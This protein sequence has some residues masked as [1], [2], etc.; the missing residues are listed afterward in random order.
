MHAITEYYNELYLA[1]V[2]GWKFSFKLHGIDRA[3]NQQVIQWTSGD[4]TLPMSLLDKRCEHPLSVTI[5]V[6]PQHK[7]ALYR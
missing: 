7:T 6:L 2:I 3:I 4:Y 5:K 1:N